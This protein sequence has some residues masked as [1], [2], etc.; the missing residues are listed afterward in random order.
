MQTNIVKI[1][2]AAEVNIAVVPERKCRFCII[3]LGCPD[4][5][6]GHC[7]KKWVE[8][9]LL[10]SIVEGKTVLDV[11][12]IPIVYCQTCFSQRHLDRKL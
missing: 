7:S 1:V 3:S 9:F 12:A 10:C 8:Y 11:M 5:W 6:G 2:L 4:T